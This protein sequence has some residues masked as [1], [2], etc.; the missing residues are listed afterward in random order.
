MPGKMT[1]REVAEAI[2]ALAGWE[3][4]GDRAI[5]RTF[6]FR[7]HITAV[8]FVVRVA[9]A[10]EVMDHHPELRIVYNR[11]EV[12]LNSHDVGGVTDRDLRLAR[13]VD[14]YV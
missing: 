2:G 6:E 1:A 5:R 11:V 3:A 10:A 7:D 9:M 4:D 14:A 13:K 12:T 8:G